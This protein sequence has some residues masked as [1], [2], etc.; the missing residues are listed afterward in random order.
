MAAKIWNI[1]IEGME[2][3]LTDLVN[4]VMKGEIPFWS[5]QEAFTLKHKMCHL[6]INSWAVGSRRQIAILLLLKEKE[7]YEI[8]LQTMQQD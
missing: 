5:L 2:A 1:S 3:L 7:G 8:F 6:T 4:G